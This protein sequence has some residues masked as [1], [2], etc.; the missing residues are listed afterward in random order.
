[1]TVD[2][3]LAPERRALDVLAAIAFGSTAGTRKWYHFLLLFAYCDTLFPMALRE[4]RVT[5]PSVQTTKNA[6]AQDLVIHIV[7]HG[8]A[9]QV[10]RY[11]KAAM[12]KQ[13]QELNPNLKVMPE[14]NSVE[15]SH[16]L[17]DL[18]HPKVI[19]FGA[20]DFKPEIIAVSKEAHA[21]IYVDIMGKT[22]APEGWQAALDAGADGLQSYRPGPLVE[23]L[24]E[25]GY[26]KN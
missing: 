20:G 6:T 16:M 8:M 18:L 14:S 5:F 10:V 1:M 9:D 21:A 17:V 25:K 3:F 7:E 2:I 13:I 24:R 4:C 11:C 22:D 26:K 12:G 15:H 23:W 19:A